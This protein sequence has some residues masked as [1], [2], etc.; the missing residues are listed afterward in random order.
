MITINGVP[1]YRRLL[2]QRVPPLVCTQAN[3]KH[4]EEMGKKLEGGG[5]WVELVKKLQEVGC[6]STLALLL[7]TLLIDAHHT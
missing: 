1:I 4:E 2:R 6:L 3:K 7:S 5:G